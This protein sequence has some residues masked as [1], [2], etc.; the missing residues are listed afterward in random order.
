ME[1]DDRDRYVGQLMGV[2]QFLLNTLRSQPSVLHMQ[3]SKYVMKHIGPYCLVSLS[4]IMDHLLYLLR[5][6]SIVL[7]VYLVYSINCFH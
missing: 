4:N 6:D 7:Y 3:H 5:F 2:K 1:D